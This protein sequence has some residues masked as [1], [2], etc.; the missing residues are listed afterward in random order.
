MEQ[1]IKISVLQELLTTGYYQSHHGTDFYDGYGT[2]V[3]PTQQTVTVY[4]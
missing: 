2:E 3:K 1:T 4:S